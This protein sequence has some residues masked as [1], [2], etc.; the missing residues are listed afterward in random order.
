LELPNKVFAIAKTLSGWVDLA[1]DLVGE[2]GAL[3]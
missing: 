3:T 2:T 1:I